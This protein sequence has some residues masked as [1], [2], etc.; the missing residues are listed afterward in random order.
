MKKLFLFLGRIGRWIID[1]FREPVIPCGR[2]C[3]H[4]NSQLA[5]HALT[6]RVMLCSRCYVETRAGW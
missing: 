5:E 1:L 3:D 6:N 2:M 4:C